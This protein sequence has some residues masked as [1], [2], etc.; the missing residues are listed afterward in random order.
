MNEKRKFPHREKIGY[1]ERDDNFDK[2]LI[3]NDS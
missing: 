2:P 1:L 3:S